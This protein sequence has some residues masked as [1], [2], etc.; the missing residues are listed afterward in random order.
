VP[1]C[2]IKEGDYIIA[3]DD[4]PVTTSDNIYAH[5]QDK[6]N[7]VIRL[8]YNQQP[9]PD[10][11][12]TQRVKTI[13]RERSIRYREWVDNNRAHVD[14]MSNGQLGYV[15]IPDMGARGLVEFARAYYPQYYK[16]GIVIDERYNGGGFTADMIIDRLERRMWAVTQSREGK[17]L[18]EPERIFAG[19]LVVLI[20]EDTGSSGEMF[21]EAIKRKRLAKLIGMR[22]WGGSV[23]IEPHED[24]IDHGVTTPPQ[25]GLYGLDG[26]WLIE[27]HGVDPN[28]EVQ[29]MPGDV[30]QGHDAQLDKA[31]D[32]LLDKLQSDPV[33]IPAPPKYPDKSKKL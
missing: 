22:T 29:N 4:E 6:A 25:F 14:K 32:Y 10:G 5:L 2:T 3:I 26:T 18:P 21:A 8:T 19:H 31:I 28:I 20:N 17:P 27:G 33:E 16:S 12:Q 9:T 7:R 23:G 1:G 13:S 30:L 11:A 15:H 24:L